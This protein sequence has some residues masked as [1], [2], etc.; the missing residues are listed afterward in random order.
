MATVYWLGVDSSSPNDFGVDSNWST[1]AVP[2]DGDDIY[3]SNSSVSVT[4]G[5]DQ[6]FLSP[7]S[8]NIEK[9][10]T[11]SIG[12][13]TDY[14]QICPDVVNIGQQSSFGSA[15]GQ[16]RLK[17]DFGT[18]GEYGFTVIVN[19]FSTSATSSETFLPPVQLLGD[20]ME[21]VNVSG[22]SVGLAVRI[23]ETS[24]VTDLRVAN[25]GYVYCGAG[26]TVTNVS[27]SE[28]ASILNVSS[29]PSTSVTLSGNSTFTQQGNGAVTTVTVNSGSSYY[30]NGTGT[31]T[32]MNCDGGKVDY[33]NDPRAKTITNF[34]LYSASVVDLNNSAANVALTNGIVLKGCGVE[35]VTLKLGKNRTLQVA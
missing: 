7:S 1:G 32:T 12:T 4:E 22:G 25:N 10:F 17:L 2:N 11:G 5:L 8:L 14:L 20:T 9:S 18:G 28:N 23:G 26:A 34:N 30:H 15:T 29:H 19:V 35:D 13:A 21:A 6:S 3:F 33:T 24:T 16:P 27:A 31:V